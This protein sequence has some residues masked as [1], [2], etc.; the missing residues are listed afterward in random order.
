MA[1]VKGKEDILAPKQIN[2]DIFSWDDRGISKSDLP[3][4][5]QPLN[6]NTRLC[7]LS[8]IP[9]STSFTSLTQTEEE[10]EIA[11]VTEKL[12]SMRRKKRPANFLATLSQARVL[13][14][15]REERF[16]LERS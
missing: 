9:S 16:K 3:R 15:C 11:V 6:M 12:S 2:L 5:A 4:G 7:P 8:P 10:S 1:R 14:V 13:V